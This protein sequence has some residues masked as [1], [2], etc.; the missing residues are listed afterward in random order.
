MNYLILTV[1]SRE[2]NVLWKS[3]ELRSILSVD[4]KVTLNYCGYSIIFRILN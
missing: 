1:V 3:L 4:F 2:I